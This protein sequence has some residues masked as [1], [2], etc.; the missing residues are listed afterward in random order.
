MKK[1]D[2]NDT[3]IKK[4]CIFAP[5]NCTAFLLIVFLLNNNTP[6]RLILLGWHT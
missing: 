4:Y 3:E 6:F 5:Q 1:Q 2:K